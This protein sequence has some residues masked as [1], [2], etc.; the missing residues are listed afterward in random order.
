MDDELPEGV[1]DL[2]FD[3]LEGVDPERIGEE[4]VEAADGVEAEGFEIEMNGEDVVEVEDVS[5]SPELS[6]DIASFELAVYCAMVFEE[7]ASGDE[8]AVVETAD[9]A[10]AETAEAAEDRSELTSVYT[11]KASDTMMLRGSSV[12]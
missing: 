3:V 11:E 6:L 12:C 8:F 10:A 9:P 2:A 5:E 4:V 1:E 7:A